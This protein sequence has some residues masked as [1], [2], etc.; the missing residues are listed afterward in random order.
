MAV[1]PVGLFFGILGLL[2]LAEARARRVHDPDEL[3]NRLKLHVLGVVPPLPR[4]RLASGARAALDPRRCPVSSADPRPVHPEPGPPTPGHAICS[5]ARTPGARGSRSI[6]HHQRPATTK[7][8]RPWPAR[9]RRAAASTPDLLTLLVDADIRN[10]T[11]SRMFDLPTGQGLVN[12]L[13]GRRW[14]KEAISVIGGA[15][16]FHLL[17]AGSL[18]DPRPLSAAPGRPPPPGS[19]PAPEESFDMVIVDFMSPVLP[20]PDALTIGR[21]VDGVAVLCRPVRHQPLPAHRAGQA[22]PGRRRRP[23][24][25][26]RDQRGPRGGR[27][28]YY[29]SYYPSYG[30]LD[31]AENHSGFQA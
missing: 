5:G 28:R 26:G 30:S 6:P 3:P 10:P 12:V 31:D 11:L 9:F 18:R 25:R 14:P 2:V 8:R 17:P 13:R 4:P 7:A 16:R 20:V 22:A 21:W 29:G 15:A 1:A 19:W 23:G 24:P 27:R